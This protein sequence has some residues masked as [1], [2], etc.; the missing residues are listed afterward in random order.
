M[1]LFSSSPLSETLSFLLS[2]PR[3]CLSCEDRVS[4]IGF[5]EASPAKLIQGSHSLSGLPVLLSEG[6]IN[7]YYDGWTLTPCCIQTHARCQVHHNDGENRKGEN[8]RKSD[9][10]SKTRFTSYPL[11]QKQSRNTLAVNGPKA[12]GLLRLHSRAHSG[13]WEPGF[14]VILS[15]NNSLPVGWRSGW[16]SMFRG[17]TGRFCY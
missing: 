12:A 1:P 2:C 11:D 5:M 15:N 13:G 10:G 4:Y 3:Y 17:W 7:S 16:G 14:C 8:W 9:L 6:F